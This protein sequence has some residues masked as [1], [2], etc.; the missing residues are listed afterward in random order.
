[1]LLYNFEAT[2]CCSYYNDYLLVM[3]TQVCF[4]VHKL[5]I[6][7]ALSSVS[8]TLAK[9]KAVKK[10]R[11]CRL[12]LMV[13]MVMHITD[14]IMSD[15]KSLN[16]FKDIFFMKHIFI[17]HSANS[18]STC[19]C[20]SLDMNVSNCCFIRFMLSL[21]KQAANVLSIWL[22]LNCSVSRLCELLLLLFFTLWQSL[23]FAFTSQMF[24]VAKTIFHIKTMK[25]VLIWLL[26]P[27]DSHGSCCDL[28]GP[29]MKITPCQFLHHHHVGS[30]WRQ[31]NCEPKQT[32]PV[33]APP[34]LSASP[35]A[36][37]ALFVCDQQ[38][39]SSERSDT[40]EPTPGH[41]FCVTHAI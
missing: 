13:L 40:S 18:P 16:A 38:N 41:S 14:F 7:P 36:V 34:S 10:N 25:G 31:I 6:I 22:F 21:I 26:A 2:Y 35:A 32:N 33:L 17:D 4:H 8:K 37:L 9:Q 19:R 11:I 15:L 29:C 24:G 3:S 20:C 5:N 27:L 39:D 1:M 30:L 28:R 12:A 23:Y